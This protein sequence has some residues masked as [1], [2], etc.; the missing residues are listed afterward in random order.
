MTII[1]GYIIIYTY[2]KI[3]IEVYMKNNLYFIIKKNLPFS[4]FCLI[5]CIP[6]MAADFNYQQKKYSLLCNDK[7]VIQN[8]NEIILD[9]NSGLW[10]VINLNKTSYYNQPQNSLCEVVINTVE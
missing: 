1:Q 7:L 6:L 4:L 5:P 2:F 9:S 10:K 3:I 8:S